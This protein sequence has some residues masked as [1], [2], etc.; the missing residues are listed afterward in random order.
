MNRRGLL[1]A[2]AV[3]LCLSA[4][5]A[6]ATAFS[7]SLLLAAPDFAALRSELLPLTTP[8]VAEAAW[9]LVP[10]LVTLYRPDLL[11]EFLGFWEDRCGGSEPVTRTRL[12]AAVW[13]RAFD[14]GLYDDT[15]VAD[16]DAWLQR[17]PAQLSE[18]RRRYDAFTIAFADQLLPHQE[19]DSLPEYFCLL[20]SDRPDEAADVLAGEALADSWLRWYVDHPEGT[21]GGEVV[22]AAPPAATVAAGPSRLLL[23]VGTWQPQGD[24]RLAGSHVL[25]GGVLEQ[26][27]GAWFLRVPVEV[28]LGRTDRPYLVN[29]DGVRARSDRFDAVYLGVEGGRPLLR[30]GAWSLEGFAGLGYD[31]IRPFLERDIQLATLNL[32]LGLGLRW[33]AAARPWILGL[34]ARRE[35][36]GTRNEGADSLAGGAFSL[37]LGAGMQFG[38]ATSR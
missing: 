18:G 22:R 33:Q 35:W 21:G 24:V 15:V 29:Q 6:A 37:R 7:D 36:L 16:L 12:L 2:L 26:R 34:D 11:V 14:E 30:R 28:R 32:N 38:A 20:Y 31:G 1:P 23:T 10:Q 4:P 19:A 13:D 27:V 8:Q 9:D 5:A 25:V 17:D 3:A